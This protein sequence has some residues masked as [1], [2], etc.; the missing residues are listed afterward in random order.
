MWFNVE[1]QFD[2]KG[3][4]HIGIVSINIFFGMIFSIILHLLCFYTVIMWFNVKLQFNNKHKI[5]FERVYINR[6][7][8]KNSIGVFVNFFYFNACEKAK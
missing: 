8:K 5:L 6:L 1:L 3:K 4:T 7:F 2:N